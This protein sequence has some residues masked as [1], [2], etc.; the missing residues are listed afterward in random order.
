V[1]ERHCWR[2]SGQSQTPT[3]SAV[4]GGPVQAVWCSP[5]M[6]RPQISQTSYMS[7]PTCSGRVV[8]LDRADRVR[9]GLGGRTTAAIVGAMAVLV[10]VPR[11]RRASRERVVRTEQLWV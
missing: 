11:L 3:H 10:K 2:R 5:V 6:V 8:R 4:G 7:T 1:G 9:Q